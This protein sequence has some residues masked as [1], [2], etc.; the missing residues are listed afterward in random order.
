M[1]DK[2]REVLELK[3]IQVSTR[4]ALA[5]AGSDQDRD[6]IKTMSTELLGRLEG[7]VLRDGA[8]PEMIEAV[9]DARRENWD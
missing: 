8:D 7:S 3:A 2:K 4:S 9:E 6:G 5:K 1:S